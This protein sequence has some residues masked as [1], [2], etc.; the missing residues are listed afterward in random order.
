MI[1]IILDKPDITDDLAM[2]AKRVMKQ[3]VMDRECSD[4][5]YRKDCTVDYKQCPTNWEL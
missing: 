5:V 2:A 4:C 1:E 3:Y